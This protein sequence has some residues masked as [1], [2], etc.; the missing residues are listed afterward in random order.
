MTML[1]GLRGV[2]HVGLTVPDIE[3]AIEFFT[4]AFG[5]SLVYRKGPFT[6]PEP[7]FEDHLGLHPATRIR[8]M[9]MLRCAVGANIE[10]FEYDAPQQRRSVSPMSDWGWQHVAFY[11]DDVAEAADSL[12]RRGVTIL[13]GV[14]PGTG[15]EA[16]PGTG[17]VFVLS[18]WGLP[19][20]LVSYPHGRVYEGQ[21]ENRL[22]NPTDPAG[23]ESFRVE[24]VQP[25]EPRHKGE[26]RHEP[27]LHQ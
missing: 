23:I 22:W 2:D 24:A 27:D 15:P 11:V 21:T 18:P 14:K 17:W 7:W 19:I 13:D 5:C 25:D 9:A 20:E 1:R 12:R 16:G 8:A 6:A 26:A 10:L 4:E 3:P